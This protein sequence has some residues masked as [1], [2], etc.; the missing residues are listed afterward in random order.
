MEHNFPLQKKG[1]SLYGKIDKFKIK[2]YEVSTNEEIKLHFS[3]LHLRINNFSIGRMEL[4]KF[5]VP[6][7]NY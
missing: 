4:Y 5:Y 6:I 1:I 3:L 2:I 7:G